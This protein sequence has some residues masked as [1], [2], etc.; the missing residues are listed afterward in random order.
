MKKQESGGHSGRPA[1][2]ERAV[3]ALPV[4]G[5]LGVL[6]LRT[7][8]SEA[9]R[10][11]WLTVLG[12]A[13]WSAAMPDYQSIVADRHSAQGRDDRVLCSQTPSC[14]MAAWV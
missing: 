11:P 4:A 6:G 2:P 9:A 3:L 7:W 13:G 8:G 1:H 10:P 12:K 5:W 14:S